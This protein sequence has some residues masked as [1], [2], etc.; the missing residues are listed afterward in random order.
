M[1]D[2][3]N[4]LN[5]NRKGIM[6]LPI[7]LMVIMIVVSISLPILT[8]VMEDSERD[9]A[10]AEMGQEADRFMNA[11]VLAHHSGNGSSRTVTIDLPEGCELAVG[12]DG[13]DAFCVRSIFGGEVVSKRY[14]ETPVLM[15]TEAMTFTGKVSLKLTSVDTG[16]VPG[17]EVTVL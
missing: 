13:S 2:H 15:I 5:R 8:G 12:G 1:Q 4:R 6:S 14:F 10:D 11:A 16:S 7:K 17:I 9:M 3:R